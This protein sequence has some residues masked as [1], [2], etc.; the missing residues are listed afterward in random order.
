MR[1]VD[2][3]GVTLV[4]VWLLSPLGGQAGLR[5]ATTTVYEED[6]LSTMRYLPSEV[7][8]YGGLNVMPSHDSVR[9]STFSA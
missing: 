7:E 1:S 8:V 4:F 2:V 3:L 9:Y 6:F 5:M